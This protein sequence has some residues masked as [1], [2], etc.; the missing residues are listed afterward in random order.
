MEAVL[1]AGNL[2]ILAQL[3][4]KLKPSTGMNGAEYAASLASKI[5]VLAES[6][7]PDRVIQ[8]ML[9]ELK[10]TL[11]SCCQELADYRSRKAQ[12]PKGIQGL[13]ASF[14]MPISALQTKAQ[15]L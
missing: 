3:A 4:H 7:D 5:K 15:K 2:K 13:S 8:T 1:K 14:F 9:S 10:I 11:D 12:Q 6:S